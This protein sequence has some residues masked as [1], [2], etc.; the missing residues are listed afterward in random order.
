MFII[1]PEMGFED[2]AIRPSNAEY[3]KRIREWIGDDSI[4]VTIKDV[5]KWRI[6][7]MVSSHERAGRDSRT[8]ADLVNA[9]QVAKSYSEG[10]IFCLGDAVHR[11]P[12]LNGLGSNTCVQDAFNLAW[13][14]AYVEQ[15]LASPALLNSFSAERQPIG[16]GVIQR[17]NQGLRDH[18]H[19]WDALGALPADIAERK[20][21]HAELS[22]PTEAGRQRRKKLQDAVKY[23]EHEFGGIG[24]E[25]NQRYESG[26]LIFTDEKE[27]RRPPPEDP[28]LQYQLSTYP[29]SRLPH[30]WLNKRIPEQ[31]PVSTIDLAGHGAFCLLTGLGGEKWKQA[32]YEACRYLGVSINAYSIGWK[33][34]WED[35]Y[36]DWARRREIEEDGCV[37]MRPDRTICW[38]S[39]EMRED[40][41]G[42]VLEVIK[43]VLGRKQ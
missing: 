41:N 26:A 40:C 10:N 3:M 31:A 33:Q 11:H 12:P 38:R 24:V 6:N 14:L 23:T 20:K 9:S 28:V 37:L 21:L 35:V 42:V 4:A 8:Q 43:T 22:A 30:A 32:A 29:G 15:G 5:S 19:V 16:A 39:M 7:E 27:A 17:A 36:G 34:D 25:M 18:V 1:F 13:K 2:F